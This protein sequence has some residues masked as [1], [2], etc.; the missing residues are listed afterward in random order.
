MMVKKRMNQQAPNTNRIVKV[1]REIKHKLAK[2]KQGTRICQKEENYKQKAER[3]S[4]MGNKLLSQPDPVG[5]IT[6]KK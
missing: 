1:K 4:Q 2:C 6:L 3:P 5:L